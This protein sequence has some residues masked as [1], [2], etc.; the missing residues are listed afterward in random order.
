[1]GFVLLVLD[2]LCFKY[3]VLNQLLFHVLSQSV[4]THQLF[5]QK[6]VIAYCCHYVFLKGYLM[7][8]S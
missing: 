3:V 1:M 6:E 2:Y 5:S 4:S 7:F 8:D